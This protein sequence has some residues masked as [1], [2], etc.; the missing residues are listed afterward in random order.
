MKFVMT[1]D[2]IKDVIKRMAKYDYIN[3]QQARTLSLKHF[4][5][6]LDDFIESDYDCD[7]ESSTLSD[8][9]MNSPPDY[10]FIETKNGDIKQYEYFVENFADL[11]KIYSDNYKE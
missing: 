5:E 2:E 1:E 8:M 10:C 9:Y 11:V 6:N 3:D 7:Y 4:I